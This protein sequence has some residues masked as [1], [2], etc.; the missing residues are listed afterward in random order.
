MNHRSQPFAV[1]CLEYEVAMH[2]AD[3]MAVGTVLN[4][5]LNFVD[6]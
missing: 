4:L 6:G 2:L 5:P 3:D 1:S